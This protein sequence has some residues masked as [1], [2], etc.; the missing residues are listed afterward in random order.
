VKVPTLPQGIYGA[1]GAHKWDA[2][3]KISSDQSPLVATIDID[4]HADLRYVND[5]RSLLPVYRVSFDVDLHADLRFEPE[6]EG[7]LMDLAAEEEEARRLREEETKRREEAARRA[8][9]ERRKEE[10]SKQE[11]ERKLHEA[12][13]AA[14][15]VVNEEE[16]QRVATVLKMAL[17]ALKTQVDELHA[18]VESRDLRALAASRLQ[19]GNVWQGLSPVLDAYVKS[20]GGDVSGNSSVGGWGVGVCGGGGGGGLGVGGMG[21]TAT[22]AERGGFA[23]AGGAVG[24]SGGGGL[25]VRQAGRWWDGEMDD[26][27][28]V[29]FLFPLFFPGRWWWR[30][31][32]PK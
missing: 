16:A 29:F 24:G 22:L 19:A 26:E 20:L 5:G 15:P 12:Q 27:A 9:E 11:E 13:T 25:E 21:V 30:T 3:E 10:A 2:Q 7:D 23:G 32:R 17:G 6:E 31:P 8:A 4:P 18:S 28:P 1:F 14:A